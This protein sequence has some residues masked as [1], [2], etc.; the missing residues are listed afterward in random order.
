[1]SIVS[2]LFGISRLDLDEGFSCAGFDTGAGGA[3]VNRQN[4]SIP[5]SE[6]RG[7]AF[8]RLSV[9]AWAR[10]DLAG[11]VSPGKQDDTGWICDY[12]NRPVSSPERW[13]IRRQEF[14]IL[15][16]GSV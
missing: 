8:N 13:C 10:G 4:R 3:G 6:A 9:A 15:H 11:S 2:I 1:M 14:R 7:T 16:L 12:K 5:Y